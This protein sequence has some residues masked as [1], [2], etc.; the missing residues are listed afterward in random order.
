MDAREIKAVIDKHFSRESV[1]KVA[2][3]IAQT[4]CPQTELY[5]REPLL[6]EA[7]T[8]FYRPAYEACGCKTWI[9]DYGNLIATQGENRTGKKIMFMNYS[10]AWL[11][12]TMPDP[13]SGEVKDGAPYGVEG[14]IVWGRGG[15]EYHPSNA[16]ALE[17]ARIVHESGV[18]IPGQ[19]IYVVSSGGHTSSMDPVYH[20]VHND[21]IRADMCIIAGNKEIVIGNHG[22]LDLKVLVRGKSVHS[23]GEIEEG[24]NAIE[25]GLKV[26][27]RLKKIM[28]FPPKGKVDPDMGQGRLSIIGLASYPFSSGF[29]LGVGSGGHTLQNLM[30]LMLDRRLVPGED[31]E[32]A[33]GEIREALGDMSPYEVILERGAFQLPTKHPKDSPLVQSLA[34]AWQGALGTEPQYKYVK[35]TI[36]AGYLNHVGIPTIMFGALDDRFAHG[37]ADFLQLNTTYEIV[38]IF[39]YWAIANS[40]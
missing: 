36:D 19:I 15:S 28:P 7:I 4:P 2:I 32:D 6:L 9:D 21:G 20:L 30:R 37:D 24:L 10:M 12:G 26:I 27:E 39:T 29:H 13:W 31:P 3:K 35:Y 23:G 40:R 18:K 16:A 38:K 8:K 34:Q 33:V 25:G 22:R 5:E 1:K 17:C 11:E 14:E